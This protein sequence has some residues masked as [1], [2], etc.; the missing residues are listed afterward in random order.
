MAITQD[1]TSLVT[2][3]AIYK[4]CSGHLELS[5]AFNVIGTTNNREF[6]KGDL[7]M[8]LQEL[9]GVEGTMIGCL[10]MATGCLSTMAYN[11]AYP[12]WSPKNLDSVRLNEVEFITKPTAIS[13]E[14]YGKLTQ[15][16]IAMANRAAVVSHLLARGW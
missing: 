16:D 12:N 10:A 14:V 8:V 9:P 3:S 1:L 15:T 5:M 2:K 6:K 11:E 7:V 4:H 13:K